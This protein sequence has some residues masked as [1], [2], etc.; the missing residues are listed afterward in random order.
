MVD[1][2]MSV[3]ENRIE[4]LIQ[5]DFLRHTTNKNIGCHVG[6]KICGMIHLDFEPG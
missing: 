3:M 1:S 4:E 5:L 6:S 2:I